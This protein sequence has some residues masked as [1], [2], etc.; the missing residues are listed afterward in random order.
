MSNIQQMPLN[1]INN[2]ASQRSNRSIEEMPQIIYRERNQAPAVKASLIQ[3][4]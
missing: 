1:Q 2:Q 4:V 3:M